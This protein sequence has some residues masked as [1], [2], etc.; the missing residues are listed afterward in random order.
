MSEKTTLKIS[1]SGNVVSGEYADIKISGSGKIDG[2]IVCENLKIS[3]SCKSLGKI[4]A[5]T[6]SSSG[7]FH[8]KNDISV[9]NMVV[10]GSCNCDSNVKAQT[11]KIDGSF[12]TDA[13]YVNAEYLEVNGSLK[14][15]LEINVG[16]LEVNG[17]IKA[18]EIVGTEINIWKKCGFLMFQPKR[19]S[20]NKVNSI[21]CD[22]LY[23]KNLNCTRICAEEITLKNNCKVEVVE[24]NG[25]LRIDK[26]TSINKIEGTC[27]II[28]E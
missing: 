20:I 5:R 3:G 2:D 17:I 27:E 9:E 23:A 25:I 11:M 19:F 26:N 24:C 22:I 10:S 1:G 14:N 16:K 28:R 7:S 15:D 4:Q 18:K 12:K 6:I 13:A 21:T 8:A